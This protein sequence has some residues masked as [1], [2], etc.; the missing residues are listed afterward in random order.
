MAKIF[1]SICK[2]LFNFRIEKSKIQWKLLWIAY[3][4]P[5]YCAQITVQKCKYFYASVY[6]NYTNILANCIS[7]YTDK[8]QII[9]DLGNK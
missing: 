7:Q 8:C 5:R 1:K 2:T 9:K 3:L 4:I 6:S